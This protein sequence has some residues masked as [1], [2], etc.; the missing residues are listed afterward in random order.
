MLLPGR[1][2]TITLTCSSYGI[3]MQALHLFK[4][5][6]KCF[7]VFEPRYLHFSAFYNMIL[8]KPHKAR[9]LLDRAVVEAKKCGGLY[10]IEWCLRSKKSW[11]PE[12]ENQMGQEARENEEN[13][14]VF[15]FRFSS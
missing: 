10:D 11:F 3:L 2:A 7:Y 15:E 1:Y 4:Q 14:F 13:V 5:N 8:G 12:T 6:T 9:D